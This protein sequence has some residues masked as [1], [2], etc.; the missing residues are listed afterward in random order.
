MEPQFQSPFFSHLPGELRSQIWKY[1][2]TSSCPIVDPTMAPYPRTHFRPIPLL[3]VPLLR[4][5]KR[6]HAEA[7]R[8]SLY[9]QNRFRFTNANIMHYFLSENRTNPTP[10][11][12]VEIEMREV[13]DAY[14]STERNL[15]RY[16]S[17]TKEDDTLWTSGLGG[18]CVDAPHL[19]T[20]SLN[21][22]KWRFSESLQ[23]VQILQEMLRGPKEL[24]R[25]IITGADG[26]D[27][28]FGAK[29]KYIEKWGPVIFT[30]IM[31]FG[32][33]AGMVQWMAACVKG[34]KDQAIVR[35]SK[36]KKAVSLE[37]ICQRAFTT[38]FGWAEYERAMSATGQ[39]AESGCC[40]LVEYERRWHSGEWPTGK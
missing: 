22:E 35:W 3:G 38:E 17:W 11:M 1:A 40:S 32:K 12:D 28:L 39:I 29:E 13:N 21:I 27:L 6:I 20:L 33:L 31:L 2:L 37:V 26:S 34:G 19:K 8:T 9:S 23:S 4:T 24:E 36:E 7:S 5:C 14:A 18:L 15:I 10:I 25:V 16:L 30:G